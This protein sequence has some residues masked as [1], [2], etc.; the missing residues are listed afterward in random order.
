[1]DQQA[2]VF[3]F[4]MTAYELLHRRLILTTVLEKHFGA[5]FE[6]KELALFE[7]ASAVATQGYR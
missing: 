7:Y 3:S 2:D 4:A 1:M 6:E 5:S